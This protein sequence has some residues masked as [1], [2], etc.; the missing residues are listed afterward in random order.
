MRSAA[1]SAD[2][3][4]VMSIRHRNASLKVQ[5]NVNRGNNR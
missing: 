5:S 2:D 1:R 4:L 3:T